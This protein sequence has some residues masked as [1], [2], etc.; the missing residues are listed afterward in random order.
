[1]NTIHFTSAQFSGASEDELLHQV[2]EHKYLANQTIPYEI[3]MDEAFDSWSLLVYTP[4]LEAIEA[5][6]LDDA[7]PGVPKGELT[8]WVINHWHFM[9]KGDTVNV[10]VEEAVLDYGARFAHAAV[11]R[12][13]FFLKK[14]AA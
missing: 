7:F 5:A 14:L 1:V 8:L 13:G 2:E 10:S 3:T 4:T 6:G 12:F 9:K 11:T